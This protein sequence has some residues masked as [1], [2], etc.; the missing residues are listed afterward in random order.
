M[1]GKH[2]I[3]ILRIEKNNETRIIWCLIGRNHLQQF[4]EVSLAQWIARWTS[5]PE[6][7]SSR[8]TGD[9]CILS[10]FGHLVS[11]Q[12]SESCGWFCLLMKMHYYVCHCEKGHV[13]VIAALEWPYHCFGWNLCGFGKYAHFGR[14]TLDTSTKWKCSLPPRD[15]NTQPSWSKASALPLR[16]GIVTRTILPRGYYMFQN[17]T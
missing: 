12:D 14:Y 8:L 15:L 3:S 5:N 7:V 17:Q 1:T 6:V 16:H 2:S 9:E 4:H 11:T 13:W 10:A